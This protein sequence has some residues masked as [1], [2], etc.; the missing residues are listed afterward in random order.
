MSLTD[1]RFTYPRARRPALVDVT[2]EFTS[3]A[4][5]ILGPNG[6]G[7]STLLR[8][9]STLD[10][11]DIGGF[12]VGAWSSADAG[13]IDRYRNGLGVMPQ[14]LDIF[15][16][17]DCEEFLRYV[18]WLRRVDVDTAERN[19]ADALA[20]VGL[21]EIAN[22]RVKTLSGGMRQRLGLAQ[23]L[24]N[25]PRILLLDEPTV[26]LDPAQRIDFRTYLRVASANCVVVLATH[27]VE[28]VAAVATEVLVLNEGRRM[29]AGTLEDL[30]GVAPGT[31][32]TGPDVE[33][34]YLRLLGDTT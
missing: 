32:V 27:L 7:K 30:C 31:Q 12:R 1:V 14:R 15:G 18:A 25:R 10:R 24:V 20:A 22:E 23:A 29:F 28:D 3:N 2:A 8:I 17:Y 19:V 13:D 26:G 33:G 16:G 34:A 5:A 9:L 6:A 21:T 11:P 4:I